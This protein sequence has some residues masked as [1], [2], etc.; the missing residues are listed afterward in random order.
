M[1]NR[2]RIT[3]PVLAI[4]VWAAFVGLLALLA[5][6]VAIGTWAPHFLPV[7]LVLGLL[8]VAGAMLVAG[9][10]WEMLRAPRSLRPFTWLL[11]GV[12]PLLLFTGYVLY[13][14]KTGHAR[15]IEL[16]RPLKMLLPLGESVFDLLER[17]QY[18]VRTQ[19]ETVVMISKPVADASQQVAAMDQHI[20][21][22]RTRLGRPS[23]PRRVHWVRGPLLGIGGRAL[24]GMCLGSRPDEARGAAAGFTSLDRH[25]V[26]HCVLSSFVPT[27]VAPPAVF[28]EG[29]AEANMGYSALDVAFMASEAR[30]SGRALSLRTLV[31]PA[32]YSRHR[33]PA[34]IQGAALVNY[35][36]DAYGPDRFLDLF[37][38]C[39]PATIEADCKRVLGVDLDGLDAACWAYVDKTVGPDGPAIARLRDMRVQP[40]VTR[41]AWNSFLDEY[42]RQCRTLRKP[43]EHV[44]MTYDRSFVARKGDEKPSSTAYRVTML[45]SGELA[46]A[47]ATYEKFDVAT[48]AT[49]DLSFHARRPR[50]GATWQVVDVD[51]NQADEAYRHAFAQVVARDEVADQSAL[52]RS[53]SRDL[54]SLADVPKIVVTQ[55]DRFEDA[56]MPRV[57]VTLRGT[58]LRPV[59]WRSVSIVMAA[60]DALAA[61]SSDF[62][63]GDGSRWHT[64]ISYGHEGVV[65]VVQRIEGTSKAERR[66]E[67]VNETK[68]VER[69]FGPVPASEFTAAKLL[70]GPIVHK[71]G[72]SE[73]PVYKDPWRFPDWYPAPLIAGAVAL[74]CGLIAGVAGGFRGERS[75]PAAS[76]AQ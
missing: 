20:R 12:A 6:M 34:Y 58:E 64:Q 76:S 23:T 57:R 60:D 71:P 69:T 65:P 49:P 47:R 22:L 10:A 35:I 68:V 42:A 5:A 1:H 73:N 33:D 44:R 59:R 9:G 46:A 19:G 40:P 41:A 53:L 2:F 21:S 62:E 36:L 26:A 66:A 24:Y 17:F 8:I 11:I 63:Y 38:T 32:W 3:L 72:R 30:E 55:L 4:A 39:R 56:G 61:V 50:G 52:L 27:T 45:R 54:G 25:E 70:D 15:Q 74:V 7:T 37:I 51:R 16:N 48:L 75:L 18:P 43:Y 28:S 29:W 14:F 67:R 31:S 13:G